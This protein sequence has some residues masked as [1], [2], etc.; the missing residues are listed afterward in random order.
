MIV[1]IIKLEDIKIKKQI[2]PLNTKEDTDAVTFFEVFFTKLAVKLTAGVLGSAI[3]RLQVAIMGTLAEKAVKRSLE[4]GLAVFLTL[5]ATIIDNNNKDEKK[6]L[7]DIFEK[8]FDHDDVRA[9]LAGMLR[10]K[11]LDIEE[12]AILFKDAG[13]DGET[14]PGLDFEQGMRKFHG[15]FLMAARQ[16][17]DLQRL[18]QTDNISVMTGLQPQI[19][20]ELRG[21]KEY[22]L[23][24]SSQKKESISTGKISIFDRLIKKVISEI[25]KFSTKKVWKTLTR[26]DKVLKVL[27][28]V[29]FNPS[30]L[31]N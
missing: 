14:I 31:L 29:G 30:L 7:E 11:T 26:E 4:A 17:P 27:K 21:L 8:F 16:E 2:K 22:L 10:G 3:K 25:V 1:D 5:V 19:L 24:N 18:I 23:T 28:T 9:E 15:A 20:E 12:L 6:H 13:Y